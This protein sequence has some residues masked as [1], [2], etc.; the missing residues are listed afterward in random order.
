LSGSR[1]VAGDFGDPV[2]DS[3]GDAVLFGVGEPVHQAQDS[4]A[5]DHRRFCRVQDD[6]GL[7]AGGPADGDDGVGGGFGEL[8][9][10]GACAGS[11]G[12]GGDGGDDF[13]IVDRCLAVDGGDDRDRRLPAAGDHVDV[14]RVQVLFEVY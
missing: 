14:G 5:H 9:D 12:L 4:V 11:G 8:I 7:T 10:V 3:G 13:A 6:D 1:N 2:A